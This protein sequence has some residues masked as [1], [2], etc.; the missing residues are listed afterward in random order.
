[1]IWAR[2]YTIASQRNAADCA[3][4]S[5]RSSRYSFMRLARLGARTCFF[6]LKNR[7]DIKP[8]KYILAAILALACCSSVM[9]R[10][11]IFG[12][13]WQSA[14]AQLR[15]RGIQLSQQKTKGRLTMYLARSLPVNLSDADSYLLIFD[16]DA[17]LVKILMVGKGIVAD[18]D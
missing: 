11:R 18:S 3:C 5:F 16:K 7:L 15:A 2:M 8:F 6:T 9:A 13:D 17:G 4:E 1:M 14:P 10:D 12:L